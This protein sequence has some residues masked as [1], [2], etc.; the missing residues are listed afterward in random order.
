VVEWIAR[1]PQAELDAINKLPNRE[2]V[3][4]KAAIA[5]AGRQVKTKTISPQ[6]RDFLG[7]ENVAKILTGS[8]AGAVKTPGEAKDAMRKYATTPQ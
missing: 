8:T 1:T 4:V 2:L 5:E 6:L 7:P 3:N